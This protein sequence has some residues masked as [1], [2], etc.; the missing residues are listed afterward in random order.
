MAFPA[1]AIF[2]AAGIGYK[3]Y[4][5]LSDTVWPGTEF[6][7]EFRREKIDRH[8]SWWGGF[9]F[10][11]WKGKLAKSDLTVDHIVPIRKGGKNSRHNAQVMCSS[12]NSKKQDG[13]S[14]L[15]H[16][17]GRGGSRPRRRD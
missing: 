3:V 13:V 16:F 2:G 8:W 10:E 1:W 7:E 4:Q 14:L 17:F 5:A 11:C 15:D 9:C 6:P 12:C